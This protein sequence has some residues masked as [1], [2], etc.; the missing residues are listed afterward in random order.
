MTHHD[1]DTRRI[2]EAFDRD[3]SGY[4]A[5]SDFPERVRHGGLRRAR[6]RRVR[7]LTG[8]AAVACAAGVAVAATAPWAGGPPA[9]HPLSPAELRRLPSA[10]PLGKAM[11]AAFDAAS[12]D[13]LYSTELD[14]NKGQLVDTYQDWNWPAQPVPG[15]PAR[16]RNL[17]AAQTVLFSGQPV[18]PVEEYSVS[19]LSPSQTAVN[20]Q[21]RV[22]MVCYAGRSGCGMNDTEVRARTWAVYSQQIP[23][24]AVA[25]GVGAG[26]IFSPATLVQGI[27]KG[28]WRILRHTRL[29]GQ[30]TIVLISTPSG[31]IGGPL[32]FLLWVNAR[33]YLP[34]QYHG[35]SG[36]S[37]SSGVF[38]YL[39]PTP[40][41][42]ALFR[43]PIPR[44]YPRSH[45]FKD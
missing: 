4:R 21:A 20:V 27:A 6:Q 44:G 37:T 36:G 7:R 42:M 45:P 28:Q 10:A 31:P 25:S 3:L 13:I 39:R 18:S 11:L 35:G 8:A 41:N 30:R 24:F 40:A 14:T 22:T 23:A 32:P 12:G 16:W 19:Y 26:G 5:P 43:V 17:Y 15:Q 33:T 9:S 1:L 29:D 38:V 2:R 34:V